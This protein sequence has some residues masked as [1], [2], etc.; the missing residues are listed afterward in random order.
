MPGMPRRSSRSVSSSHKHAPAGADASNRMTI[1]NVDRRMGTL[2]PYSVVSESE[3]DARLRLIPRRIR[4]AR[5]GEALL[6]QQAT[7]APPARA[8]LRV[9]VV[10]RVR[11]R[12]IDAE[13]DAPAD[14]LRLGHVHER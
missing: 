14:D 12:I 5:L 3:G 7:V 1:A 13:F 10:A 6:A 2:H 9:G 4:H 8:A 11:H